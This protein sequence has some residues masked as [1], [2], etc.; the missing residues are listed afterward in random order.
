[1]PLN[2]VKVRF[3]RSLGFTLIELMIVVAIV[4]ILAALLYPS[5][6]TSIQQSRRADATSTLQLLR[7]RQEFFFTNDNANTYTLNLA[8]LG[9]F[10]GGRTEDG[11]YDLRISNLPC[12]DITRC[13]TVTATAV[14]G[15]TQA[16]DT[17]CQVLTIDN[18]GTKA[19]QVCWKR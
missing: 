12:N 8:D 4:G 19:P 18:T 5:Y 15:S 10:P 17:G 1:M 16:D 2:N 14:A 11:Y 9:T 6:R 7:T 13:Y 3:A